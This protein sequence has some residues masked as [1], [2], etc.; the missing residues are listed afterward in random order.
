MGLLN[1]LLSLLDYGENDM[2]KR[3][4]NFKKIN[5]N[6]LN[7]NQKNKYNEC[8]DNFFKAKDGVNI[9]RDIVYTIKDLT[10]EKNNKK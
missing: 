4:D 7:I 3:Y 8:E 9:L 2:D 1:I 10:D 6:N 5:K